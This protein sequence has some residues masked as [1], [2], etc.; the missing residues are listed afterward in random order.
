MTIHWDDPT[1]NYVMTG[2]TSYPQSYD[3]IQIPNEGVWTYWI[4]QVV[5][6]SPPTPHPIH[7]HG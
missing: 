4:I 1:L 7:L 2:N 6:G 5:T 3:V